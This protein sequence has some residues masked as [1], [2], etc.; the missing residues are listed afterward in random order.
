MSTEIIINQVPKTQ[1]KITKLQT[2]PRIL[3]IRIFTNS[4]CYILGEPCLH[5]QRQC[6]AHHVGMQLS[7]CWNGCCCYWMGIQSS[8]ALR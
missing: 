6:T 1:Q 4:Y 3:Q 8:K 7:A 2:S 5:L